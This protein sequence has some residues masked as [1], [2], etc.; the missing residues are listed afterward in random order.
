MKL[1]LFV[2]I[3]NRKLVTSATSDFPVQLPNIFREDHIELEIMLLEPTGNLTNPLSTVDISS[4]SIQV[5]I[6]DPDSSPEALQTTFSKDTS[7]NKFSGTL[8]TNTSE[9][10]AAFNAATGNTISRF[11]EI[12]VEGTASQYHTVLQQ[13]V[14]LSKDIISHPLVSPS[15]VTV[16]TA[17]ANSFSATATDSTT[18]EWTAS[19]DYNYAHLIGMS[20]L[21]SLTAGQYLKV[22]SAGNWLRTFNCQHQP[23]AERSHRCGPDD[24]G[25][26]SKRPTSIRRIKLGARCAFDQ[27]QHRRR[28]LNQCAN[29]RANF[30]L[31]R[32]QL[33]AGRSISSWDAK[34]LGNS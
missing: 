3:F 24:H 6:G 18:V 7:T 9:M 20:G 34:S 28:H 16:G 2:D 31:E 22:N 21:S 5:A 1:K 32:I 23:G 26:N 19:G 4:L 8:N 27:F 29:D 11:L 15:N 33:G 13:A 25:A 10:I 17:F 12:E 14:T 30:I